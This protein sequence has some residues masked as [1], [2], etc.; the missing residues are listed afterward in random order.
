MENIIEKNI[1]EELKEKLA[2]Y[3][4]NKQNHSRGIGN[5]TFYVQAYLNQIWQNMDLDH[6]QKQFIKTAYREMIIVGHLNTETEPSAE[7]ESESEQESELRISLTD[8]G[9]AYYIYSYE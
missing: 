5:D 3:L 1:I 6:K 7:P 4:F 8:E 9:I 2:G